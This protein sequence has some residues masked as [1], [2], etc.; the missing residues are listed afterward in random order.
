M[1]AHPALGGE[2]VAQEAVGDFA[3]HPRHGVAHPGEQ[4]LRRAVAVRPGRE[5]RGHERVLVVLALKAQLLARLPASPGG[6][7]GQHEL[8][9]LGD[10][11]APGHREPAGDV[12][13]DLRAEAEHEPAAG[14][15][16]QVMGRVREGHRGA[17]ERD[18]DGRAEVD[19]PRGVRREGQRQ[20][21]V[22]GDL[23]GER[24]G[25]A[26]VLGGPGVLRGGLEVAEGGVNQ[27]RA[28]QFRA[29]ARDRER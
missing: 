28:P 4:D 9:H 8:A 1:L 27:H 22:A 6:P 18:R 23:A 20:E 24:P 17:G 26:R 2:A 19:A 25:V 15:P 5:H 13:P 21:R 12:R 7:H 11:A 14:Q 16:L 3:R 10:R 29:P